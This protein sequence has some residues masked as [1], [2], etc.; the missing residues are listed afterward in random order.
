MEQT[1]CQETNEP[2]QGEEMTRE[3]LL[4]VSDTLDVCRTRLS[5]LTDVFS[6][7]QTRDFR[8]SEDGI[9]GFY[10]ILR[11]IEENLEQVS[12]GILKNAR[13]SRREIDR[14][15]ELLNKREPLPKVATG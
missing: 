10:W 1:K 13:E 6:Q 2:G 5:F 12:D 8:F 4:D 9:N 11:N 3:S 15:T 14:L 7:D